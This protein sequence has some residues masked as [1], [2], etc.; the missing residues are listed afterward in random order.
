M[1]LLHFDIVCNHLPGI[2]NR[3]FRNWTQSNR[4]GLNPRMEFDWLQQSNQLKHLTLCDFDFWTNQTQLNKSIKPIWT[5]LL[6]WVRQ[7]SSVKW[8]P[9]DCIWLN[10]LSTFAWANIMVLCDLQNA[11]WK[12]LSY[13]E[14]TSEPQKKLLLIFKTS[15]TKKS[16]L[17][18]LNVQFSLIVLLFLLVHFGSIAELNRTQSMDWVWFSLIEFHSLYQA[19]RHMET[20]DL[21]VWHNKETKKLC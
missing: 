5:W 1:F 4:I 8:N 11:N 2:V 14:V 9:T 17:K 6:D 13:T 19:N 7:A 20:W 18:N 15:F 12:Q 21:F 16:R 10:S 3:R